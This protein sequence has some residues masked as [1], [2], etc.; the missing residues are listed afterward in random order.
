MRPLGHACMDAELA[1]MGLGVNDSVTSHREFTL[2]CF[3]IILFFC[4]PSQFFF[5]HGIISSCVVETFHW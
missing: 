4:S 2:T 5:Y 1:G 3:V